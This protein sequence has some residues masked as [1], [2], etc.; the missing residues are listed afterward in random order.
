[1]RLNEGDPGH[2]KVP[3]PSEPIQAA[4]HNVRLRQ[5]FCLKWNSL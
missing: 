5:F 4:F 1:L 2:V 3:R